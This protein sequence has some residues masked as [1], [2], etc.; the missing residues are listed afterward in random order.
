MRKVFLV[1]PIFILFLFSCDILISPNPV[2]VNFPDTNLETV[3]RA[4]INKLTGTI[5]PADLRPVTI[6]DASNK[7][8]TDITGLEWCLY[9]TFL[10]LSDN[11]VDNINPLR[12]ISTLAELDITNNDMPLLDDDDKGTVNLG[13]ISKLESKTEPCKITYIAGNRYVITFADL[14]LE[15][16]IRKAIN[17][18]SGTLYG[19]DISH[20]TVLDA[21]HCGI[22]DVSGLEYLTSLTELKLN[23]NSISNISPLQNLTNLEILDITNNGMEIRDTGGQ[24]TVNLNI[25]IN[26]IQSGCDVNYKSGNY[27]DATIVVFNDEDLENIIRYYLNISDGFLRIVDLESPALT[28][29]QAIDSNI[30]DLEGIQHCKYLTTVH[31]SGNSITDISPLL[32]LT[33]LTS[34]SLQSNGMTIKDDGGQGTTNLN[35]VNYHIGNGCTV[36]YESGNDT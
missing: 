36:Y 16:E 34:L 3:I 22:S 10:D 8:I 1:L 15:E 17:K 5:Y 24:S 21:S 32:N 12:D 20:L 28:T 13:V 35:V 4:K 31:L 30:S 27:E 26:H 9:L 23:D 33:N 2:A 18:L 14:S 7:E 19:S 25:V 6:L 11:S 29:L